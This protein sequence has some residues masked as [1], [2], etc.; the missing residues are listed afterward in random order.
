MIN[1]VYIGTDSTVQ[2]VSRPD[3]LSDLSGSVHVIDKNQLAER[4]AIS[5]KQNHLIVMYALWC[6]PCQE[7][8]PIILQK[9]SD[10]DDVELYFVSS[11]DWLEIPRI[12][13]YWKTKSYEKPT[14]ILDIFAYEHKEKLMRGQKERFNTFVE[15]I[16]GNDDF[17]GG[18]PMFILLDKNMN[19]KYQKTG[20]DIDFQR[21]NELIKSH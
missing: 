5:E 4:I 9:F 14:Y 12:K 1:T 6:K 18:F 10:S 8:M 20:A 13:S 3:S 16:I 19:V 7:K 2:A 17:I 15:T 11:D 21:L